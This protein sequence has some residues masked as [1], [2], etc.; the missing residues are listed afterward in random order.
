MDGSADFGAH[1]GAMRDYLRAGEE[2]ARALGNRG[3]IRFAADGA[4]DPG[5]REA[6]SRCGFYVFEGVLDAGE[7]ADIEKD[8][9]DIRDR[10]PTAPGAA[11]DAK[12]RPALAAD[13][14]AKCLYW[15]KPLGDPWGGTEIGNRRHQVEMTEPEAAAGAPREVV[16][17][18]VG[19]LQFSEACLRVYGHPDLLAVAAAV[20]GEDFVPFNEALFI[21]EPG[22]GASVAW[23]QDGQTHWNSPDWDEGSHG[24][25]FMA[26]L[27]GSTAANGLWIV[28]GSHRLGKVDIRSMLVE[29]EGEGRIRVKRELEGGWFQWISMPTPALLTI[30]SGINQ[31]RYATLRGIMA[32]KRKEVRTVP[33][34]SPPPAAWNIA[35]LR[36]PV[37]DKQTR[38]VD[39]PPEAAAAELV[40]LLRDEARAL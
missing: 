10:L 38:F 7:L 22:L 19:S 11:T 28:P 39:G 26:Q 5:I 3:P 17:L 2:R 1:E 36:V 14:R 23:H 25:N 4:L 8:F 20:N 9:L 30:Q 12:G 31:L 16:F 27:Y 33:F 34:A 13:N 35:A 32:A 37:K 15:A 18:I 6:Y 24:F 29:G 21:K 40:R